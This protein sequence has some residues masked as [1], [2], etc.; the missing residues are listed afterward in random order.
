MAVAGGVLFVGFASSIAFVFAS[1]GAYF[2]LD[3]RTSYIITGAMNVTTVSYYFSGF[4]Y[5]ISPVYYCYSSFSY[6]S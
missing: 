2:I 3:C 6:I 5:S 4:K 1:V